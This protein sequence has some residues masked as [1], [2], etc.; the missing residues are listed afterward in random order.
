[1]KLNNAQTA[2]RTII[3]KHAIQHLPTYQVPAYNGLHT[4]GYVE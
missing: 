4:A 1:M 2:G 3:P